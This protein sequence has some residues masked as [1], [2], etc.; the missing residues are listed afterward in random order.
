MIEYISS[1]KNKNNIEEAPFGIPGESTG[2]GNDLKFKTIIETEI[3]F[4]LE[5]DR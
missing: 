3:G 2:H 5:I 4:L 1:T